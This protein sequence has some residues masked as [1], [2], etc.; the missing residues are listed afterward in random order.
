MD[1]PLVLA[2]EGPPVP[3]LR[4]LVAVCRYLHGVLV[5][6]WQPA[7]LE[8]RTVK[9]IPFLKVFHDQIRTHQKVMTCR[10]ACYGCAGDR[11][12][13]KGTDIEIEL[14]MVFGLPLRRVAVDL[15]REE[16]V[17]NPGAF[18]AI[19]KR[20]HRGHYDGSKRVWVHCFVK[21]GAL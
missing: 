16:G 6:G 11:L 14:V 18:R 4:D 13:V 19:W 20:L 5:L 10:T 15:Y 8:G 2:R 12:R 9:E 21:L 17:E 1:V 3:G 7:Y